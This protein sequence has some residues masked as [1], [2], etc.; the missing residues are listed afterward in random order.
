MVMELRDGHRLPTV[1][2]PPLLSSARMAWDG[3]LLEKHN[4]CAFEV[5]DRCC[6]EN[7]I[8]LQ[9]DSLAEIEW[10][11][12]GRS[13]KARISPGQITLMPA[14]MPYSARSSS[15]GEF[16]LVS[17]DQKL[18][19]GAAAESG[20]P[21]PIEL[22]P[23][24][25]EDDPLARELLLSLLAQAERGCNETRLYAESLANLL[26]VHLIRQYSVHKSP[27]LEGARGLG[28]VQLRRVLD[29]VHDRASEEISLQSMADSAGLSP[30]HFARLFKNA[31]G[32]T[33]HEYVTRCRAEKA[34]ELLLG[35]YASVADVAIQAGFYD[36]SHLSR[37]FKKLYGLTPAAFARRARDRKIIL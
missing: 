6:I 23:V 37:H 20:S 15:T 36:Q 12:G 28:R 27:A 26:A 7:V 22:K 25:G 29:H 9:T 4:L 16:L 17:L 1:S 35:S 21:D 24:L 32:L 18:L 13:R 2:R 14:Q 33:P 19:A 8:C 30:F 34:R 3:F 31:T 5:K 11:M 10:E